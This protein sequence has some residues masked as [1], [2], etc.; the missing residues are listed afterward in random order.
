MLAHP[1]LTFNEIARFKQYAELLERLWNSG[2]LCST[3]TGL[4][5]HCFKGHVSNCFDG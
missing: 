5:D 2:Y 4:V 1:L 3:L